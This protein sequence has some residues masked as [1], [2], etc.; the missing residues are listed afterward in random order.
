MHAY[1]CVGDC[2]CLS[3]CMVVCVYAPVFML[4]HMG[5]I[6]D[7][8]RLCGLAYLRD[9]LH[10]SLLDRPGHPGLKPCTASRPLLLPTELP[11]GKAGL[12]IQHNSYQL[13]IQSLFTYIA[14]FI[15]IGNSK[16]YI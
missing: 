5:V 15:P 8:K 10:G 4:V 1:M 13:V 9:F 14:Q 16:F 3:V 6:T 2:V 12:F 7:A 11:V